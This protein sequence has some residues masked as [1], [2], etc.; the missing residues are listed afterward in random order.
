MQ[1][2]ENYN[3]EQRLEEENLIIMS[4]QAEKS[5][6]EDVGHVEDKRSVSSEEDNSNRK[7]IDDEVFLEGTPKF[8]KQTT[9]EMKKK[10]SSMHNL[11]KVYE[12]RVKNGIRS[13]SSSSSSSLSSNNQKKNKSVTPGREKSK[14]IATNIE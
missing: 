10:K 7:L 2:I 1:S 8:I 11:D 14:S 13:D 12:I 3:A 5:P 4:A 6:F 9:I